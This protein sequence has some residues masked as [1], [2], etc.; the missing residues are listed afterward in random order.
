MCMG[1]SFAHRSSPPHTP[2]ISNFTYTGGGQLRDVQEG[3]TGVVELRRSGMTDSPLSSIARR[4]HGLVTRSQALTVISRNTLERWVRARRLEPVRRSVYRMAGAPESWEQHVLAAC[5][6]GGTACRASFLSAAAL[7]AFEDFE[8]DAIAITYFGARPSIIEGVEIHESAVF[9]D[10]HLVRVGGIPTTSVARTL[11][12]LTA[13]VAPWRVERAVDEALRRKIM[14]LAELVVVAEQLEGRGRHRCTVM[15]DIL[16]HR[17]PGY[18]PGESEPEK[19]I[20][21]LLVR[22]GLPEPVRQHRVEIGRK[23]YR[24]DLCYPEQKIAIEYDGFDFHAGRRAFDEDR[25]RANDL[26]LLGFQVLRFTSRS[27]EHTIVDTVTTALARA[28]RS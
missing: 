2:N 20:A 14:R 4:Q 15:R 1:Q 11:C 7:H 26:V 28:S 25:A 9:D 21:A 5:L 12:D 10:R 24:I 8:R 22:A 13:V 18:H 3:V 23:R 19:R 16:R 17:A 6:A 27:S